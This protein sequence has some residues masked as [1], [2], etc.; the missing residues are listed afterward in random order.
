MHPDTAALTLGKEADFEDDDT[1]S[2]LTIASTLNISYM[3]VKMRLS[4]LLTPYAYI[5]PIFIEYVLPVH[6]HGYEQLAFITKERFALRS[7]ANNY[8]IYY[9]CFRQS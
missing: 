5:L 1:K 2:A 7:V 6:T 4:W 3:A 9:K 8:Y